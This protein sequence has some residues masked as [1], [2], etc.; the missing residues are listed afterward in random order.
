MWSSNLSVSLSVSLFAHSDLSQPHA[1]PSFC[2]IQYDLFRS[3]YEKA[4]P[5][6]FILVQ[7]SCPS[8]GMFWSLE[9]FPLIYLSQ[10]L[11]STLHSF[12]ISPFSLVS[13]YLSRSILLLVRDTD[14]PSC[15]QENH[16]CG[17]HLDAK[18]MKLLFFWT[19]WQVSLPIS[20][21]KGDQLCLPGQF[22]SCH[23]AQAAPGGCLSTPRLLEPAELEAFAR[24][25]RSW[26]YLDFEDNLTL[27]LLIMESDRLSVTGNLEE[28]LSKMCPRCQLAARQESLHGVL[29]SA[30]C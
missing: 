2:N 27:E 29:P 15:Q 28:R 23:R 24:P 17:Q 5:W 21:H 20:M 11:V 25:I 10:L 22:S 7:P 6:Y 16:L 1:L 26:P 19:W 3:S 4:V 18:C 8:V 13:T 12:D 14:S 9:V 30:F